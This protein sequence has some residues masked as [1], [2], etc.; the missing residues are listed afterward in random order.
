MVLLF[1]LVM[2]GTFVSNVTNK[3]WWLDR[4]TLRKSDKGFKFFDEWQTTRC[5]RNQKRLAELKAEL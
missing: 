1:A 4:R 2:I 5:K 3:I